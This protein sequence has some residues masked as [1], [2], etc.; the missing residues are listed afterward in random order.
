MRCNDWRNAAPVGAVIEIQ[1]SGVYAEPFA[2]ELK[3]GQSLQ[4]RAAERTRP[5][6]RLHD[7]QDEQA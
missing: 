4:L 3:A 7:W 2:V 6:L 5:V 1:D